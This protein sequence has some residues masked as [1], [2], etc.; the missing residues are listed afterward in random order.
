[1]S[2]PASRLPSRL[3]R[4]RSTA[5]GIAPALAADRQVGCGERARQQVVEALRPVLAIEPEA[6]TASLEQKL[7]APAAR[8]QGSAVARDDAHCY[9]RAG[10]RCALRA[11][12]P[13]LRAQG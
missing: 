9:E 8:H 6:G 13:A 2:V 3:A 5:S 1:M 12:Q 7:A 11:D 10:A 4:I